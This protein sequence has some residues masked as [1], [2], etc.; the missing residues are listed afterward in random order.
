MIGFWAQDWDKGENDM[1]DA[2][3]RAEAFM[4]LMEVVIA[5]HAMKNDVLTKISLAL[6]ICPN[7]GPHVFGLKV[8]TRGSQPSICVRTF[9]LFTNLRNFL[10]DQFMPVMPATLRLV[11]DQ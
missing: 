5:S 11:T 1:A 10:A 2:A 7:L 3:S 9:S 8:R 6:E 4:Q